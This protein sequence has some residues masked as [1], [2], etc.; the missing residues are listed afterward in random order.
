MKNK[1][2]VILTGM[3][4]S[5]KSTIGA[6]LAR[7]LD[8]PFVD[9][10]RLIESL[11]GR[12]LEDITRALPREEF[13]DVEC[14]IIKVLDLPGCV[15]ATGGSVIYREDAM[16]HLGQLGAIIYLELPFSE[17]LERVGRNPERGISFGAGQSLKDLFEERIGLYQK[18]ADLKCD[19]GALNP[20]ECVRHICAM[21]EQR[22]NRTCAG[23]PRVS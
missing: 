19:T 23:Q 17:V 11:Y 22:A 6:L 9:T 8:M 1:E 15:I 21:L 2:C 12:R 4:G 5:G 3:P 7:A 14:G 10:D 20:G 18:Y 16:R 13:L